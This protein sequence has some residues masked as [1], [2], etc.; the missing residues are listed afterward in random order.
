M[1]R[2]L[3]T[4]SG[5]ARIPVFIDNIR[6]ESVFANFCYNPKTGMIDCFTNYASEAPSGH[7]MGIFKV[8]ADFKKKEDPDFNPYFKI[9]NVTLDKNTSKEANTLIS[10]CAVI[11]NDTFA[12]VS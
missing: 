5:G 12:K 6:Y 10:T 8:A 9:V 3:T 11:Y 2:T 7:V 4:E 1:Q